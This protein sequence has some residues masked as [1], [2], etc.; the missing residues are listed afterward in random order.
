MAFAP[1]KIENLFFSLSLPFRCCFQFK[2]LT[3]V[4]F[5]KLHL[6]QLMNFYAFELFCRISVVCA[7]NWIFFAFPLSDVKHCKFTS[8]ID[9]LSRWFITVPED[10]NSMLDY[11][12]NR[13]FKRS[14]VWRSNG[15][16]FVWSCVT[17]KMRS[18]TITPKFEWNSIPELSQSANVSNA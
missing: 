13:E 8:N 18:N 14:C 12:I 11:H 10:T 7:I 3:W 16:K 9:I 2:V 6:A 15:R 5:A 17:G 4:L 1:V